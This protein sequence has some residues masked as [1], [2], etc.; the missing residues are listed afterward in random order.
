MGPA[1][2]ERLLRWYPTA[3]R[4][5]YGDELLAMVEDTIGTDPPARRLRWSLAVSGLRERVRRSWLVGPDAGTEE[6]IRGG[7]TL[8]LWGW[9]LL[10]P[11]GLSFAKL[12]E[13]WDAATPPSDRLVPSLAVG[14]AQ[15]LAVVGAAAILGAAAIAT[16][17]LLRSL[18]RGAW[19]RLRRSAALAGALTAAS[20]ALTVGAAIWAHHLTPAQRNGG[21]HAYGAMAYGWAALTILTV[22]AWAVLAVKAE[23]QLPPSQLILRAEAIGAV[24]VTVATTVVTAAMVTWWASMASAAPWFLQGWVLPPGHAPAGLVGGP[25]LW[26]WRLVLTALAMI[27]ATALALTGTMRIAR[28]HRRILA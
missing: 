27:V 21:D 28:S 14:A 4:L 20:I 9:A 17:A 2:G 11:A 24:T 13:H 15:L 26:N 6:R 23:R 3:W 25:S 7:A 10:L 8:V 12:V 18:R 5:R 16:P 1:D 19:P 22:V